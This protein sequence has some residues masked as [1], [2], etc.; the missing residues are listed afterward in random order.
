MSSHTPLN[1]KQGH[2]R[3]DPTRLD[4]QG[5][6]RLFSHIGED[7]VVRYIATQLGQAAVEQGKLSHPLSLLG[8]QL[9]QLLQKADDLWNF[10]TTRLVNLEIFQSG[11]FN[12]NLPPDEQF[13]VGFVRDRRDMMEALLSAREAASK[14]TLL[15]QARARFYEVLGQH[16]RSRPIVVHIHERDGG[17]SDRE[18]ARQR[19]AGQNP[20]V[21]RRVQPAD[22][23]LLQSWANVECLLASG[24]RVALEQAATA[25]RLFVADYP[26]LH[27]LAVADLQ[28]GRYVGSPVALFY[29]T[30]NVLEPL[31]IQLENGHVVTPQTASGDA[32]MQAKLFTQ[33]A[34]VTYHELIAHLCDT[35][36]AMEAFAI[37]TPRH[38]PTSHPL[39][40]LLHPHFQFLLAINN[41][42]N[43]ILLGEGAAIDNLMAPTREA[44]I[45]LINRAYRARSFGDY[46]LPKNIRQR[47]IEAEFLPEFPYRDDALLLWEAINRYVTQ[48]LQQ[49]YI[50]DELIHQ[51]HYLQAWAAELGSSLCDRPLSDFPQ[52]PAWLPADAIAQAGLDLHELPNY[53]RVPGFPTDISNLQQLVEI[54]TQL[55]FTCGP[56]HAAVNFSQFDYVGYAPNA[57]L[58][59]YCHPK[60][61]PSLE[62][63]LPSLK[64]DLGQIELSF[65]LS[66]IR[67]GR[68]GSSDLID[69]K[70]MGDR[71]ALEQF[72]SELSAIEQEISRRNHKRVASTGIAYPYLLP[73]RIPN[74]IN[75]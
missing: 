55:I 68:L 33:V 47:G 53:P 31:V 3:Y 17:L 52:V 20:M 7:G 41:R 74:S 24:D 44:S 8:R 62:Q 38:L 30:Q 10:G 57:P 39:Y 28:P 56:Q 64:Q 13:G 2:Y 19:L 63:L 66:G 60:G 75:I 12:F 36:L 1:S 15:P 50:T 21:L 54:A 69:F 42:G 6:A 43:T 61:C 72:R 9:K 18:F 37:A 14:E 22:Q 65:A 35:H 73:S 34:D 48:F 40:R 26:L 58:S 25:N 51:D 16:R 4:Q 11:W 32:W 59:A 49:Y 70:D 23:P 45:G 46:A 5:P 29:Q 71:Q 67:W 27:S